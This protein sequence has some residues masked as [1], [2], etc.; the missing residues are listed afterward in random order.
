MKLF[1]FLTDEG[2]TYSGKEDTIEPD[3]EN[4]QVLGFAKGEDERD[5][6]SSLLS[7]NPHISGMFSSAIAMEVDGK[8][9]HLE[10]QK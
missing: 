6:L 10:I 1:I 4:L 7:E 9:T 2:F 3:V 8:Q 5:A